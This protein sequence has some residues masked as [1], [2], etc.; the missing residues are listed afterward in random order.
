MKLLLCVEFFH[1][2]IGGV[3]EVVKQ[4]ALGLVKRGHDVTVAT[5]KLNDR[6]HNEWLGV[7]IVEFSLSGNWVRG[8][9]GD[10]NSYQS[11]VLAGEFDAVFIYAAQ[12]WTLDALLDKLPKIKARKVLVPCGFS[13]LYRPEYQDYFK[14]L[15]VDLHHFD[16]LV[17]HAKTYRDY[18]F[19][20]KL[21]YQ[22]CV[23]IPNG[24]GEEDF[25]IPPVVSG[26]REK[27]QIDSRSFV[28]MTIGSLNGAKGHLELAQA[29]RHLKTAKKIHLLLNGNDMPQNLA[30]NKMNILSFINY[31]S[32]AKFNRALSYCFNYGLQS[33]GLQST[34]LA[35]LKK[36]IGLI[37]SGHYGSNRQVSL[38]NFSREE[39]IKCLFDSDLFVFASHI[40]YSPLV[41]FEAAAAG[42]PFITTPVGNAHE[43]VSW[44]G[45]GQLCPAEM[46]KKG[47]TLVNPKILA[48]EID[49]LIENDDLRQCMSQEGRKNWKACFT[50][51]VIVDNYEKVLMG[52]VVSSNFLEAD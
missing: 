3:Q 35:K 24:A 13:G 30:I 34:Y 2:S 26:F 25:L 8:I 28:L 51:N 46:N 17:F 27:H 36:I 4:L 12:Q 9:N 33:L 10:V 31:F 48:Q 7:R 50:W 15:K 1:P 47:F 20:T 6:I 14:R 49:A 21:G 16:A 44:T 39:L 19:V 32:W 41:L 5:S 37:N 43:I 23:L 11:F 45:G 42:L 38:V 22:K 18:E 40:E 52:E 29:V